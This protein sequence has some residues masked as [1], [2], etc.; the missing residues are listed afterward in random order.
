MS[1]A[2]GWFGELMYW[3]ARFFPRLQIV[4]ATHGMVKFVRGKRPVYKGP[5]LHFYW[6]LVTEAEVWPIVRQT[7]VLPS[8]PL[9][10]SDA[11][12]IEVEVVLKYSVKDLLRLI[13]EN[14]DPDSVV[15]DV[16]MT[17]VMEMISSN[18]LEA[19]S[20]E[21]YKR[22]ATDL[23]Q[24]VRLRLAPLGI[25]TETVRLA[26]LTATRSITHSG[27][28]CLADLSVVLERGEL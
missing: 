26:K 6:P 28:E 27:L 16:A 14:H 9:R 13:V 25:R 21:S 15:Q 8:K 2:L 18:T 20:G 4:T 7:A 19:M 11:K 5:G 24:H 22:F 12:T 3:F 10:T 23:T 1:G 17:A